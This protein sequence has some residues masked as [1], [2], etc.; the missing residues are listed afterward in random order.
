LTN[1]KVGLIFSVAGLELFLE[2][3][4]KGCAYPLPDTTPPVANNNII[5]SLFNSCENTFLKTGN[6]F[7]L[8]DCN[9]A[10]ESSSG[11][12]KYTCGIK[13]AGDV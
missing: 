6:L 8:S 7:N 1:E 12:L 9:Y 5:I 2:V 3:L 13:A 4:R 10:E 11:K